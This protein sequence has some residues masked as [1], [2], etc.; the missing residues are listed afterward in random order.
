MKLL[1]ARLAPIG[2]VLLLAA[3][4]LAQGPDATGR[5]FT[6]EQI[7]SAPFPS[8]L[9]AAPRGGAVAWVFNNRGVRNIWVATAPGYTGR[10]LTTYAADEGQ[11][12][13]DLEWTSD[14]TRLVFTRGGAPNAQGQLP[15]PTSNPS[16]VEQSVWIVPITGGALQRLAEGHSPTVSSAGTTVAFISKGQVWTVPADGQGKPTQAINMRGRTDAMRWSP[17]GSRIAVISD[18]DHHSFLGVY[19]VAAKT[20][21][22]LDA[23]VDLDT[24]P[25]WSPDGRQIAMI[26]LAASRT[27]FTFGP[28]RD[29]SPWS[30][31]IVDVESGR[32][33]EAWKAE[34]GRGSA[35]RH[36]D[37]DQQLLWTADER[38]VF[39]WERDGWTHLYPVPTAPA[40][41]TASGA[42]ATLLTPGAFEVEHWT[43]GP[44][45][46]SVLFSSNQNDIDRRHIWRVAA[47]GGL[48]T[49]VTTGHG[50]EWSPVVLDDQTVAFLRSDARVPAHPAVQA[51]SGAARS[52][53]PGTIP[54]DFP[55]SALVE[56]EAVSFAAADGMRIR[57]SCSAPPASRLASGARPPSSSMADRGGRCSWAGTTAATITTRTRSTSIWRAADSWS[58]PSITGA[59]SA[60][61]WSS[62]RR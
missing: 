19:D 46:R 32:G 29:A 42:K 61:E 39:P 7:M 55:S 21:R 54:A 49:Q 62:A 27:F 23:S 37:S 38:L 12:I 3:A 10:Q 50:I 6:L 13:G 56:P 48:P 9:V 58:S 1:A 30:I 16:G 57:A 41:G 51:A 15:N 2:I 40:A 17:D 14:G 28:Q 25:V 4:P 33:R 43:L 44:D 52:M 31:R 24:S 11:D 47:T 60:T 20:L 36:L 18:R 59:A 53:A 8:S 34:A 35:F 22:F 5:G 26:R 45:R